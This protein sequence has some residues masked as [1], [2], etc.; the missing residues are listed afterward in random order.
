M[1]LCFPF[2]LISLQSAVLR[3]NRANAVSSEREMQEKYLI[4]AG[5][6][7][8]MI[9]YDSGNWTGEWWAFGELL[10]KGACIS[11]YYQTHAVPEKG[12]TKVYSTIDDLKLRAVDAKHETV[13]IDFTLTMQWMDP[14]IKT[15]FSQEDNENGGIVLDTKASVDIWQPDLYI[16][17][18][19]NYKYYSGSKQIKSLKIMA[20]NELNQGGNTK[21]STTRDQKTKTLVKLTMEVKTSIYCDFDLST[22]PMDKQ[23]CNFRF[24]SRS[25]GATFML[26]DPNKIYHNTTRNRAVNF[27]MTV[28]FFDKNVD[29]GKNTVGF[30]IQIIRIL[31]PFIMKYYVPCMGIVLVSQLSFVIPPS[32]G[33]FPGRVVLLVTQFLT[34]TSLFIH[35]MVSTMYH[36]PTL[37]QIDK[38]KEHCLYILNVEEI[39]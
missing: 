38:R 31:R 35:Q 14:S 32:P 36:F 11:Y 27:D 34:L 23:I 2:V 9:D 17:N 5:C 19:S 18:L 21:D 39:H 10:E 13:S 20:R 7:R 30:D 8:K 25:S 6:K 15:N 26:Y 22:Y 24:G 12:L 4:E 37:N 16:Y 33:L 3:N 29:S 28:T 1:K